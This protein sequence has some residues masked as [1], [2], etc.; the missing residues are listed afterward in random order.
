[1]SMVIAD[2][3]IAEAGINLK[4]FPDSASKE[5]LSFE[6]IF[7]KNKITKAQYDTSIAFYI[8]HPE[9]LNEVYEKVLNELSKMQGNASKQ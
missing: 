4:T 2:I 6:K 3:H 8:D 9:L 5:N 1:M 7:E